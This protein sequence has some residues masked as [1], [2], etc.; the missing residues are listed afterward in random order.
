MYES[1]IRIKEIS[2]LFNYLGNWQGSTMPIRIYISLVEKFKNG[3]KI[4]SESIVLGGDAGCWLEKEKRMVPIMINGQ[5]GK[6]VAEMR[7]GCLSFNP[8]CYDSTDFGMFC[9]LTKLIPT[10]RYK[11]K[12]V[13]PADFLD[14]N[15]DV[16]LFDFIKSKKLPA[17]QLGL[18]YKTTDNRS[19]SLTIPSKPL[20]NPVL[21]KTQKIFLPAKTSI[22]LKVKLPEKPI[23]KPKLAVPSNMGILSYE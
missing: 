18:Q 6:L 8:R 20:Q 7:T 21:Q 12:N 5:I 11:H 16:E 9:F 13:Y 19:V 15:M 17:K 2:C 1:F 10:T 3:L 14:Y 22:P 23:Q 4:D